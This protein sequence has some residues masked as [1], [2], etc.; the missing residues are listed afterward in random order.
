MG[1]VIDT[2]HFA[3][4]R[5]PYRLRLTSIVFCFCRQTIANAVWYATISALRIQSRFSDVRRR[6]P[7]VRVSATAESRR[8]LL[9]PS[10]E[11]RRLYIWNLWRGVVWN[12]C[13]NRRHFSN[14][15]WRAIQ[16]M[17]AAEWPRLRAE[18]S[19]LRSRFRRKA[20]RADTPIICRL[21]RQ[22]AK[23]AANFCCKSINVF[24]SSLRYFGTV[25]K[26]SLF[27]VYLRI[28]RTSGCSVGQSKTRNATKKEANK[29][30]NNNNQTDRLKMIK[31]R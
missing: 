3:Y 30:N 29:Q 8:D 7:Y 25:A 2:T 13:T 6:C 17:R 18:M 9:R 21:L 27:F 31:D 11:R 10:A 12:G 26:V 14:S 5:M 19:M 4:D 1:C 16:S 15:V 20:C 23:L 22:S 28:W 24:C